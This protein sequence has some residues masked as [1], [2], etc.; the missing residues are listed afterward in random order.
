M[1]AFHRTLR[2]GIVVLT[3]ISSALLPYVAWSAQEPEILGLRM[4]MNIAAV[5][6]IFARHNIALTEAEAGVLAA[7]KGPEAP[8][9][10]RAVRLTFEKGTLYKIVIQFDTPPHEATATALIQAYEAEKDRLTKQLGAPAQE[11]AVND[12]PSPEDRYDWIRRGRAYYRTVWSVTKKMNV[13]L[14][15]YSE[16]PGIVLM[17]VYE[18]AESP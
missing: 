5:R 18:A 13:A 9:G 17:E 12:A 6:D 14:W 2:P 11:L 10:T 4:G 8:T 3:L 1:G 15:L 16:D 7:P